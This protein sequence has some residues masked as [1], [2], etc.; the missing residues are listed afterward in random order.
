MGDRYD[1]GGDVRLPE[2]K[3]RTPHGFLVA[4][5]YPTRV[6]VLRYR[7]QGRVFDE[8]R[9]PEE[10]ARILD[11]IPHSPLVPSHKPV[12]PDDSS[13]FEGTLVGDVLLQD[14]GWVR[15][16]VQVMASK[17]IADV[18]RGRR[19]QLS[20]GF[21]NVKFDETPGRWDPGSLTYVLDGQ[22]P[23]E[24]FD[25]SRAVRFDGLQ[26]FYPDEEEARGRGLDGATTFNHVVLCR[27]GRAGVQGAVR[28]DELDDDDG[29]EVRYDIVRQVDGRWFVLSEDG[30]K[31]SK[32]YETKEEAVERLQQIEHFKRQDEEQE[33]QTVKIKINGMEF[34]VSDAVATALM[35]ER[36]Q[37]ADALSDL[38]EEAEGLKAENKDLTAERDQLKGEVKA[39]KAESTERSD[40]IDPSV[41]AERIR[42]ISVGRKVGLDYLKKDP[43]SCD[44]TND[45]IR[46]DAV[47][48]HYK[49]DVADVS[50]Q[51][52]AGMFR[53]LTERDVKV[54]KG[55][56]RSVAEAVAAD[57]DPAT[58]SREDED[59]AKAYEEAFNKLCARMDEIPEGRASA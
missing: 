7:R 28:F 48:S 26:R 18:E 30:K 17:A 27:A 16:G 59:E 56:L 47:A 46:R 15:T 38:E 1:I 31:L 5:A 21:L 36:N 29:L 35:M 9:P 45:Q 14:D 49:F 44:R 6:G 52:V 54:E 57:N 53:V 2:G 22:D 13:E 3:V 20:G 50:D 8:L 58:A 32:G 55:G 41:L 39:L 12:G 33:E 40:A 23:P 11:Q 51:E 34:D 43:F 10:L 25:E 19:R 37:R 42:V 4:E 24:N